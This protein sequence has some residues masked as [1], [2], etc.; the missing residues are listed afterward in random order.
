[1]SERKYPDPAWKIKADRAYRYTLMLQL[2]QEILEALGI[3]W[4]TTRLAEA[5]EKHP[6]L[7]YAVMILVVILISIWAYLE[8]GKI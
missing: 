5:L 1:M 3:V 7:T 4:L 2:R 8:A 6:L